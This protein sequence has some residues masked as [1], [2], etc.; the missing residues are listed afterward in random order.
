MSYLNKRTVRDIDV[1]N[2]RVLLRCDFNVP[3]DSKR[4]ITDTRR[5]DEALKTI[6]Y[7]IDNNAKIIICSH[8][9]NPKGEYK[10]EYS[11]KPVA[12]YLSGKLGKEVKLTSDVVGEDANKI[13][14]GLECGE[15]C[16][17]ENLRFEPGETANDEEFAKKL[18]SLGEVYVNDAF[19]TCHRAHA[20]TVGVTKFLPS[21][22]GFLIEKELTAI[23][24]LLDNPEHPFVAILGGAK[25][26]DKIEMIG[27]L[28]EQVDVLMVGGGMSYTFMNALGY[29][30]GESICESD[31]ISFAKDMMAKA[32][33]RGV[34]FL[35]PLDLRVGKEYKS[36]TEYKCVDADKIP[37]GWM[38]L[39]IGSKTIELFREAILEAK[40]IF[41]NGPMGVFEWESFIGGTLEVAKAVAESGAVSVIGGGDSAAAIQKLGL[42]DKMTHVATGGGAT[43]EF[44]S[45]KSL[46]A[47]EAIDDK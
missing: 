6:N 4:N 1:R 41:W 12:D 39:D 15:V 23:S 2:K 46:P 33:E 10:K 47:L 36:D 16:M 32:K 11:L 45:G 18:A 37:E 7:L 35:L 42:G 28:L 8:L 21:A 27:N 24:K 22:Y 14:S 17:L 20:S 44:L 31:K 9:G 29:P 30:V 26:S 13:V 19:G 3:L 43:L 40:T 38:G 5:I 25:V 34:K